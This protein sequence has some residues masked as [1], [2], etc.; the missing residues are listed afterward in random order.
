MLADGLIVRDDVTYA[1]CAR[2]LLSQGAICVDV[3][4]IELLEDAALCHLSTPVRVFDCQSEG[5]GATCN[6][7]LV[8]RVQLQVRAILTLPKKRGLAEV[9]VLHVDWLIEFGEH[10]Y[11]GMAIVYWGTLFLMVPNVSRIHLV[12]E[13]DPLLLLSLFEM[14][15]L[16]YYLLRAYFALIE[17]IVHTLEGLDQGRVTVVGVDKGVVLVR[18][19]FLLPGGLVAD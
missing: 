13:G 8:L 14:T 15:T 2:K 19:P 5:L 16:N 1:H 7:R 17:T 4:Q 18:N 12:A 11:L 6:V 3:T 10:L 9:L